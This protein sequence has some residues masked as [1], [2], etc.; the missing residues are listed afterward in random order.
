[1]Q[2]WQSSKHFFFQM[3]VINNAIF[4]FQVKAEEVSRSFLTP[5]LWTEKSVCKSPNDII[6]DQLIVISK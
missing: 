5:I 3:I 6:S 2:T 1:M 4:F